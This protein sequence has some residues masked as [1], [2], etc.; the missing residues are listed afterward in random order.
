MF[1]RSDEVRKQLYLTVVRMEEKESGYRISLEADPPIF[2]SA[3]DRKTISDPNGEYTKKGLWRWAAGGALVI[4]HQ[5][6]QKFLALVLRDAGAPSFGGHLTLTSG[7][8]SS[9]EEFFNPSFV[10]IREGIEEVATVVGNQIL[11]PM[12]G[13]AFE[14][15]IWAIYEKQLSRARKFGWL[16]VEDA[17]MYGNAKFMETGEKCLVISHGARKAAHQGIINTDPSTRGNRPPENH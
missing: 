10:A 2:I 1:K 12:L 3:S 14:E 8:S 6:Y 5:G 7:V 4:Y 9:Y 11:I 15:M 13:P 17:P 16:E